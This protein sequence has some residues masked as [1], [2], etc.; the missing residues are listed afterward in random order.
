MLP[1]HQNVC[2]PGVQP[3]LSQKILSVVI[4]F[5]QITD[6]E[7][8]IVEAEPPNRRAHTSVSWFLVIA[9]HRVGAPVVWQMQTIHPP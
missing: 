5:K 2:L 6:I 1:E 9:I 4:G 3:L 7:R 8:G